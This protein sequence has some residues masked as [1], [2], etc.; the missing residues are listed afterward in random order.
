MLIRD[1][2]ETDSKMDENDKVCHL[3]LTMPSSYDTIV[4]S[5]ETI[6]DTLTITFVKSRILDAELKSELQID[7]VLAMVSWGTSFQIARAGT[8]LHVEDKE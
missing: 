8:R 2:K 6:T 1:L 5:L 3:L 4:T 7:D